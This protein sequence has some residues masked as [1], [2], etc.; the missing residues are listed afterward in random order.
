MQHGE[1]RKKGRIG[2]ELMGGE[3]REYGWEEKEAKGK[4][5]TGEK[6]GVVRWE[7]EWVINCE[8]KRRGS[9]I[10]VQR[11]WMEKIADI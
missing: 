6:E 3:Y 1:K 5:D 10:G 8:R 11:M 2:W 4:V 9:D 7:E